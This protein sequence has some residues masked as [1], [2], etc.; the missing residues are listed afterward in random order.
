[1]ARPALV[2]TSTIVP[3]STVPGT[4]AWAEALVDNAKA[5]ARFAEDDVRPLVE[6]YQ[7]LCDH[8]AWEMWF[9]DEPKTLP[10][11]C[12]E[13]LGY[14]AEFLETMSAGVAALDKQ[15]FSG[16][17]SAQAAL[18]AA[19]EMARARE[20]RDRAIAAADVVPLPKRGRPRKDENMV[21]NHITVSG[22]SSTESY[23]RRRLK[24]DHPELYEQV[25][26][27]S[28]SAGAAAI[29]ANIRHRTA[30]VRVDDIEAAAKT[31]R[32]HY[33]DPGQRQ[34]LAE[35]LTTKED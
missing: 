22:Q 29:Q 21:N 14:E 11:F 34:A 15:G 13:V 33:K 31:L 7:A 9:T 19:K 16:P 10:R 4:K 23:L 1:M 32:R 17:V 2:S 24:R 35:L 3:E 8:R 12:R 18:D 20:A 26:A 30:S 27:G 5:Y 25:A 6:R 28:L